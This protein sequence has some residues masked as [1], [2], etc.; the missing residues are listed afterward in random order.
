L[1]VALT[2]CTGS[3]CSKPAPVLVTPQ[4]ELPARPAMLPVNWTHDPNRHCITDEGARNLIINKGRSD[5]HIEIL[6]GMV[7]A[8]GAK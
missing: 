5:T 6:E 2:V 8:G 3:A 1:A 4:L 7:K